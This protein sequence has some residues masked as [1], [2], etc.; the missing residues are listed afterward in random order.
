[1]RSV[2]MY[3]LIF[4]ALFLSGCA[5]AKEQTTPGKEMQKTYAEMVKKSGKAHSPF[6]EPHKYIWDQNIVQEVIIPGAIRGG[7]FYPSHKETIIIKPSEPV[8]VP[9]DEE[10]D[11]E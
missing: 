1:M 5:F 3:G 4:A 9:S 8:L 2:F 10:G 7:V 11:E 6:A